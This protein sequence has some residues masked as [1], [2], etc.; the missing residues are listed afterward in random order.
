MRALLN[1]P[2]SIVLAE[3]TI[4]S[5]RINGLVVRGVKEQTEIPLPRTYTRDI[6]PSIPTP[7][8]ARKWT[9]LK[10]IA[11]QLMP[12][13]EDLDVGLFF[14]IN[15]ARVIKPREVIPGNDDDPYAQR[16]ALGWGIIEMVEPGRCIAKEGWMFTASFHARSSWNQKMCYFALKT[17]T[18][19]ILTP[20]QV[21]RMFELDCTERKA[22]ERSFSYE[23]RRFLS[24]VNVAIH[25]RCDGHYEMPLPFKQESIMLPNKK[26]VAL[27]R[28]NKLKGRL[29]SD[30]KYKADYLAFMSDIISRGCAEKVPVEDVLTK[31]GQ[32]WYIPHHGVYHPKNPGKIRVV[33]DYSVEFAGDSLNR[34]L[35][36]GPDL[37]NKFDRRVVQISSRAGSCHVRY[38]RHVPPGARQP[39]APKLSPLLLVG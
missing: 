13:K 10:R 34:R 19:E 35:L 18:K 3:E 12:Y 38:R 24:K 29:K 30:S 7:E 36:Q 14:G 17:H 39:R 25:Q 20:V 15:C 6:I 1:K 26:E 9:H 33:F 22:E 21:N 11:D 32:V 5:R 31:N 2:Q 37:I 8:T 23:D 4:T 28:L 27:K 16:T